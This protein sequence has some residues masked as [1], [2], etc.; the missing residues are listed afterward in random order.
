MSKS[1]GISKTTK[2]KVIQKVRKQVNWPGVHLNR[3]TFERFRR[4]A[5]VNKLTY[6]QA[7]DELLDNYLI[8]QKQV[9][10]RERKVKE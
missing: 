10:G 2:A 8:N 7:I 1:K 5:Q 3:K 9:K 6:A 4:F